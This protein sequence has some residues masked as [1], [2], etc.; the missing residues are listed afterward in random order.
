MKKVVILTLI[1][2]FSILF[3]G[4]DYEKI[5]NDSKVKS[6]QKSLNLTKITSISGDSEV[7]DLLLEEVDI[8]N[9]IF[10]NN[11]NHFFIFDKKRFKMFLLNS[12]GGLIN[13]FLSKG[14]GPGEI[15][16][17][18]SGF[19]TE[20]DTLY[21]PNLMS[22]NVLKFSPT[23][24]YITAIHT[25]GKMPTRLKGAKD[26]ILGAASEARFEDGKSV[27][28]SM[29][30]LYD[31][32]LNRVKEIY[33]SSTSMKSNNLLG[34]GF[35]Y[36]IDPNAKLLYITKPTED[37]Y[38]IE[39][40]DYDGKKIKEIHRKYRKIRYTQAELDKIN[41][42]FKGYVVNH[43]EVKHEARFK[44]SIQSLFVDRDGLLWVKSAYDKSRDDGATY[45]IYEDGH[46]IAQIKSRS[47]TPE[48][49]KYLTIR[50]SNLY[51]R[52]EDGGIK[53]Y[54]IGLK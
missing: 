28:T 32:K 30:S 33:S 24:E 39:V 34:G 17:F 38:L 11:Q 44:E 5:V 53:V 15:E 12:E 43:Q 54:S 42:R 40:M 45:D 3:G 37:R 41:E 50:E 52:G 26:R 7:G 36:D 23:G 16:Y 22:Q 46:L 13:S 14:S 48:G 19:V 31:S 6:N 8:S 47:I 49:E 25:N 18:L 10:I 2:L 29:I 35:E 21:V 9:N 20:D 27:K 1:S 4:K 51:T